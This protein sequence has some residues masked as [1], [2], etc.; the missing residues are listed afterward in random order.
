MGV[1]VEMELQLSC[2]EPAPNHHCRAVAGVHRR[3]FA[4][5]SDSASADA[6]KLL[7]VQR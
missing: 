6:E 2:A 5:P 3:S 4:T 1:E 7:R